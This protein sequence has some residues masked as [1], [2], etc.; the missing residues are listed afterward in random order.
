MKMSIGKGNGFSHVCH[1]IDSTCN[2]V[3]ST[4]VAGEDALAVR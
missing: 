4:V 1:T 3:E 2:T